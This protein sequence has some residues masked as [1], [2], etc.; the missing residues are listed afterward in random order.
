MVQLYLKVMSTK[1]HNFQ[2]FRCTLCCKLFESKNAVRN[3]KRRFHKVKVLSSEVDIENNEV[4]VDATPPNIVGK[5]Q[6]SSISFLCT[7]CCLGTTRSYLRVRE[8]LGTTSCLQEG[9]G[10]NT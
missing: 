7:G 5:V 3:H 4:E 8:D 2:E 1:K 9:V 10:A 6:I